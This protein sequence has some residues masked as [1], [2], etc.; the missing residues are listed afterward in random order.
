MRSRCLTAVALIISGHVVLCGCSRPSRSFGPNGVSGAGGTGDDRGAFVDAVGTEDED[1]NECERNPC[2]NG[3]SCLQDVTGYSCSCPP[4]FEGANC[5]LNPDDCDPNP[6][7]NG[8]TCIDGVASY[9]CDCAAGFG[10]TRCENPLSWCEEQPIPAGV[11]AADY[12]CADLDEA[13]PAG[14]AASNGAASLRSN[15]RALSPSYSWKSVVR[16]TTDSGT[17]TWLGTGAAAAVTATVT[18]SINNSE[19]AGPVADYYVNLL[20]VEFGDGTACLRSNGLNALEV[21]WEYMGSAARAGTCTV[22]GDL[23]AGTWQTVA[24]SMA[25]ER[26]AIAVRIN[27]TVVTSGCE[28]GLD[29]TGGTV[30]EV[31]AGAAEPTVTPLTYTAYLDNVQAW[32]KR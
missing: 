16:E 8:G 22:S 24:L 10:G 32:I 26:G 5:E 2:Q 19:L 30:V 15:E 29:V 12:G 7:Q 14:W 3:G 20:C 18:A 28:V 13:M 1:S 11:A 17:L 6:C 31:R 25:R 21:D 23:A 27:D 9:T 4:G